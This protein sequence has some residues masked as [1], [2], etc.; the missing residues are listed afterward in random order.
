[1]SVLVFN[2]IVMK[3]LMLTALII[4]NTFFLEPGWTEQQGRTEHERYLWNLI[5]C[6]LSMCPQCPIGNIE[7]ETCI[8]LLY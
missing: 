8:V 5:C 3:A 4:S 1:M 2:L 6:Y 7:Q